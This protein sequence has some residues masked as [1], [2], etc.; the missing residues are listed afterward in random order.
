MQVG[1]PDHTCINILHEGEESAAYIVVPVS[2]V[3]PPVQSLL[4]VTELFRPASTFVLLVERAA[5]ESTGADCTSRAKPERR[6]LQTGCSAWLGI[7]RLGHASGRRWPA[8]RRTTRFP[9]RSVAV[10]VITWPLN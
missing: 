10:V 8:R 6:H 1:E 2:I 7:V 4:N 3:Q 9:H 5:L